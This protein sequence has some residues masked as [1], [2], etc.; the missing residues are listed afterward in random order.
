MPHFFVLESFEQPQ[1]GHFH[2]VEVK[3]AVKSNGFSVN[4]EGMLTMDLTVSRPGV[5]VR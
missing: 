2:D 1:S 5:G 4:V 3:L